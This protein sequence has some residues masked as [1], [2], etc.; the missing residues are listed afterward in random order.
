MR[1]IRLIAV[2][3]TIGRQRSM[4]ALFAANTIECDISV[5]D[6]PSQSQAMI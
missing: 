4:T 3:A 1:M 2:L 5:D 6:V